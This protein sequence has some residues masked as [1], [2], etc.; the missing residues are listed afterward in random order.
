MTDQLVGMR[1]DGD[2]VKFGF[3]I[4][5]ATPD[6]AC[7]ALLEVCLDP[8]VDGETTQTLA[9]TKRISLD[10]LLLDLTLGDSF[11]PNR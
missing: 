1:D 9:T 8:S 10:D 3:Q 7:P 6:Y 4:N 2:Q 11:N 5:I